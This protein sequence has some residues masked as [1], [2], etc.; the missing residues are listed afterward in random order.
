MDPPSEYAPRLADRRARAAALAWREYTIGNIRLAIF[1]A[2]AVLAVLV[3]A[4]HL[5]SSAWLGVPAVIFLA[6][7]VHHDGIIKERRRADRAVAFYEAGLRRI[8]DTWMGTGF[9]GDR[10]LSATHPY[11]PDLDLFG[12][13]S[14]YEL[15]CTVRTRGGEE[16]LANWLCVP[17][18]LVDLPAR[19]AAVVEFRERI[20]LREDIALLGEEVRR[21]VHADSL[22]AWGKAPPILSSTGLRGLAF[23][24]TACTV[25]AIVAD[26]ASVGSLPV[27]L[28]LTA[29][30]V[31]R[32]DP[33]RTRAEGHPLDQTAE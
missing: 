20:D 14:L 9:G 12:P 24:L 16:M 5:L 29:Q 32:L 7:I 15:L 26:V 33:A 13:A 3:F 1:V 6:L 31:L 10:F 21:G 25:A 4:Y 17:A 18:P 2:A 8:D 30:S 27:V 23:L 11:A 22:A 19:H 28:A